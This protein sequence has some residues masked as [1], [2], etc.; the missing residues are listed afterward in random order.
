ML[1]FL[2]RRFRRR[3]DGRNPLEIRDLLEYPQLRVAMG[4]DPLPGTALPEPVPGT[5]V[6]VMVRPL[7]TSA[8]ATLPSP[9]PITRPAA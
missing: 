1:K 2:P 7:A 9:I 5:A 6:P 8:A 3:R 4:L